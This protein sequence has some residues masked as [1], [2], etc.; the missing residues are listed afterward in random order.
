MDEL[1]YAKYGLYGKDY[2]ADESLYEGYLDEM[3]IVYQAT[4][5]DLLRARQN[6]VLEKSLYAKE[7][8]D[9]YKKMIEESGG[10]WIL[11]YFKAIDKEA[12]WKRICERSVKEKDANSALVITRDRF[13]RY[14][15]GFEAPDGEGEIIVEVAKGDDDQREG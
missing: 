12:L 9:Q 1:I 4:L 7:D 14:W 11:V 13:D 10:K 8:R 2:A 15:D 3:D 5:Q 6:I